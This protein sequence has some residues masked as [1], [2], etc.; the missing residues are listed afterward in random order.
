MVLQVLRVRKVQPGKQARLVLQVLPDKLVPKAFTDIGAILVQKVT[1]V[2][3]D[4]LELQDPMVIR[5]QQ[6]KQAKQ[7]PMDLAA[8]RALP[9]Q[10]E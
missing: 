10:Q 3:K 4:Q 9:V 5:D 6:A 2:P 7:D 8:N 1:L